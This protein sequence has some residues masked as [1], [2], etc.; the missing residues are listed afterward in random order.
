[1]LCAFCTGLLAPA[2]QAAETTAA[3]AKPADS[4]WSVPFTLTSGRGAYVSVII[5]GGQ[6]ELWQNSWDE[7]DIAKRGLT[8]RRGSDLNN[9]GPEETVFD[10]SVIQD[11]FS[12]DKPGEL[13]PKRGMTRP[14]MYYDPEN[15]YVLLSCV[16]P[17]YT[18]PLVPALFVSK[19]GAAGTWAYRGKLTGDPAEELAKKKIWS[20]GGTLLRLADGRWRIYLNGYGQKLAALESATLDG[21]WRFLRAADGSIRELLA[22]KDG[23]P[24]PTILRVQENEWH[25]WLSDRWP[26][27]AIWHFCSPDGLDW[28]PYGA[29]PEITRA[30]VGGAGI[31][32]LRAYLEPQDGTIRGLLSVWDEAGKAGAGWYLHTATMPTG[33]PPTTDA[34]APHQ[35]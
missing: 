22:G 6:Y 29:Q 5:R 23:G 7:N 33:L 31:K 25:L 3:P 17:G 19:T 20:D 28:R 10:S 16:C 26:P 8:V 14:Y 9:L 1:M 27:E 11:V 35:K 12:P 18:A 2:L 13:S 15:G 30:V 21:P 4:R 34:S 32:C 24:F